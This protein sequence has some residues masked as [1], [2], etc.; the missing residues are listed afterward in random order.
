V[1]F[2]D[3]QLAALER[4]AHAEGRTIGQTIR[5]AI[6]LFVAGDCDRCAAD[7]RWADSPLGATAGD[8][9]VVEVAL[10]LPLALLPEL[11]ARA[12]RRDTALADLIRHVA[13]CSL[14][15]PLG[16]VRQEPVGFGSRERHE[17]E[18]E[19]FRPEPE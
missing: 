11:A 3:R 18:P 15:P 8:S 4:K 13:C 9:G 5:L 14:S 17:R 6:A 2:L 12:A 7:G 19:R 16:R 10:L 1:P